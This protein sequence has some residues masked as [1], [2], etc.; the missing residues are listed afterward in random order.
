MSFQRCYRLFRGFLFV[1][2]EIGLFLLSFLKPVE[3]EWNPPSLFI[4]AQQEIVQ[5]HYEKA[6]PLLLE[7]IDGS[8][9][10]EWRKRAV[11]LLA[12]TLD[13]LGRVEE[14]REYTLK[15]LA[16]SREM[17]DYFTFLLAKGYEAEGKYQEAWQ[18]YK[19]M[20]QAFPGTLLLPEVAFRK[21]K[22]LEL[23]GK[24]VEAERA[25]RELIQTP[26]ESRFFDAYLRLGITLKKLGREKE[27]LE[28][29]RKLWLN[30]PLNPLSDQAR[31]LPEQL[32]LIPLQLSRKEL[33]QRGNLLF[34]HHHYS[35][36][37]KIYEEI[38]ASSSNHSD[39]SS[40]LLKLA[41]CHLRLWNN[42]KAVEL[43]LS[44][45]EKLPSAR[46]AEVRSK[47]ALLYYRLGRGET[48]LSMLNE[49][50]KSHPDT[51]S[52]VEARYLIGRYYKYTKEFEKAK[53][54]FAI[55]SQ[56]EYDLTIR[57][58]SLWHLAWIFYF[59]QSYAMAFD[60]FQKLSLVDRSSRYLPDLFFWMARSAEKSGN[61]MMARQLYEKIV[62]EYNGS[63]YAKRSRGVLQQGG[64]VDRLPEGQRLTL[65]DLE[66]EENDHYVKAKDLEIMGFYREAAREVAAALKLD[67]KAT[68][69]TLNFSKGLHLA[70]DYKGSIQSASRCCSGP[71]SLTL[72]YP[73]GYWQEVIRSAEKY[74][75]DPFFVFSIIRQESIFDPQAF[76]PSEARGLMQITPKTANFLAEE[77]GDQFSEPEKL[78][79]VDLNIDYG[80]HYLSKLLLIFNGSLRLAAAGYNTDYLKVKEWWDA[81]LTGDEEEF[82]ANI[83]Y[84]QTRK[85]VQNVLMNYEQYRSLYGET[86]SLR[87]K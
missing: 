84:H 30:Y 60:T 19:A 55:L 86:A 69:S 78:F 21:A 27:A 57:A 43:F 7:L 25:Y 71:H 28:M 8:D 62:K 65:K 81:G 33:E 46:A 41:E 11:Y 39:L 59:S 15:G 83:P 13:S 79:E 40:L 22:N 80:V 67:R 75:V 34:E 58:N 24:L 20:I 10:Q 23:D 73:L 51:A 72:L 52:A 44:L 45:K 5:G 49:I 64:A 31:L 53:E 66:R 74:Q 61:L 3:G 32:G 56:E 4:L 14:A 37:L 1:L 42:E 77:R 29:F 76:S 47:I 18:T 85:Y 38:A 12:F 87:S 17:G 50:L 82:V 9:E 36:A 16:L 68:N 2:V 63:Y 70:E 6:V 48:Y 26:Q 54:I 35:R